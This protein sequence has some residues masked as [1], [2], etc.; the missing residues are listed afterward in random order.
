M[1]SLPLEG[2]IPVTG[3]V[4]EERSAERRSSFFDKC[5]AFQ[6]VAFAR[7]QGYYPFFKP[8]AK[9]NGSRVI[10]EG[11]EFIMA[12]SNNYLGL[13]QDPRVQA[14][15]RKAMDKFGVSCSG[16]RLM[17]G[18][19]TLHEELEERLAHFTGRQ[20]ALCFTTGYQTNLGAI[21]GLVGKGE[22]VLTD[23]YSHASIMDALLL[24]QGRERSFR[25]HRYRHNDMQDLENKL[26]AI[27]PEQAK[28][29][30]TEGVFSMEGDIA[31]LPKIDR[32]ARTYNAGIYLDEAHAFGVIGDR[33]KGSVEHFGTRAH[34]DVVMCTFSKAFGS[35]GGFVAG[36][37]QIVD[38][39][40]H[41]ARS[42]IFSASM[43]PA[44]LGAVMESLRIIEEEPERVRRLQ[45][46]GER[47]KNGFQAMGFNIGATATPIVP[48]IIGDLEKMLLLWQRLY[49]RGVYVNPVI[50]PAV[51]PGRTL[52]R[53]SFMSTHADEDLDRIL[54]IVGQEAKMLKII[55]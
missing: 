53:T 45:A 40:R 21:S 30:V 12:G 26:R 10:I 42:L 50:P 23:K 16:S 55:V 4:L 6:D 47:M 28:L 7:Q 32:L 1:P 52:I 51:P 15:A 41:F 25:V 17:N 29:I 48:L 44:H 18:T 24:A 37:S 14:A 9:N 19:L 46:I 8:I 3:G 5:F 2:T 35:T 20:S 36:D 22:H 34:P 38:Y 49:S 33:G 43:P 11:R 39:I 13:A 27:P 31:P 54:D